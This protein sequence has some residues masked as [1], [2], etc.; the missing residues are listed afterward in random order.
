ME[1]VQ[2]LLDRTGTNWEVE[3]LPLVAHR[4]T[5]QGISELQTNAFGM[6][7]DDNYTHL[8]TVKGRYSTLQNKD[9]AEIMVKI[10]NR[11]GGD[12]KGGNLSKGKKVYYQLGLADQKIG[13]DT[14]KRNITC[15]N[16][17][18]G[19]SSIGFGSTNTVV[20]CSNMF[21]RAMRDLDR[22]RHTASASERLAIAVARFEE[23]MQS[24]EELMTTF[25]KFDGVV[26]DSAVKELVRNAVFGLTGEEK[27]STRKSNQL[28]EYDRGLEREIKGKGNTLWG[29]FNGVTY[30]TNHLET[31]QQ[32]A[33]HLMYG[34][35][36]KKNL[37]AF[38]IIKRVAEPELILA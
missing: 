13:P 30:Y 8:G 10:Q 15:L 6:Y 25:K 5:E 24:D 7:R 38:N 12:I 14:L 26:L 2:N 36:Y 28:N 18:D 19:S 33:K 21:H 35:G 20:S 23:A 9:L 4:I 22:F 17:H 27:I 29:L 34:G 32:D 3:K 37:K 1:T 16:S 31:P 11:F